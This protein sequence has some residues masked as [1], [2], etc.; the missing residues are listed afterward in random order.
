M[1]MLI[2]ALIIMCMV[3]AVGGLIADEITDRIERR[4]RNGRSVQ[5]H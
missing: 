3:F 1:L 2:F 5:G 4:Y